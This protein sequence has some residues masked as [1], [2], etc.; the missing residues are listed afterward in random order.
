MEYP[1]G[2]YGDSPD[3]FPSGKAIQAKRQGAKRYL[4]DAAHGCFY[5]EKALIRE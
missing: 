4:M 5:Q 1:S 3:V 2:F